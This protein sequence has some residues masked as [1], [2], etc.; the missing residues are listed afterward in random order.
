MALFGSWIRLLWALLLI[1]GGTTIAWSRPSDQDVAATGRPALRVFTDKDG[2]PQN[3]VEALAKD[4]NGYL[5]VG[6]QDGPARYNGRAWT[7]FTMPGPNPKPWIRCILPAS[8]GSLWFG[9]VLGGVIRFRE[10][11]W[12]SFGIT[13]QVFTGQVSCLTERMDG[14]ILAGTDAGVFQWD[15]RG[16][17]PLTDPSGQPTGPVRAI[18]EVMEPGRPPALWIG[19]ERGLALAGDRSWTWFT[20]RDGLPASEVWSLHDSH[21]KDGR[22]LLWVGTARGL[23]QWDGH[24][25]MAFGPKEGV[26]DN[27]VN[28]IVE[29]ISPMGE[30]TLWLATDSGLVFHEDG[31]WQVLGMD[32]GFPNRTVRSLWIE[33]VPGGERTIWAGTFG[34]LVRLSRGG[35]TTFDRQTGLPDNVVFAILESRMNTGF[36][37]GTLGGGLARYFE[38]QWQRYGLDSIIPDRHILSLL[39]TRSEAGQ[40]VLW[41]GCRSGGVLRVEG[42]RATRYTE[43]DGLPDTWTY[44]ISEIQGSTGRKEIWAGT[45]KGPAR[46]EGG[47]WHIPP[48]A[49]EYTW[50]TVMAIHQGQVPGGGTGLWFATRGQGLFLLQGSR[51]THFSEKEG[52]PDTRVMSLETIL[53]ADKVPWL[54]VGSLHGLVRRRLDTAASRWESIPGLPAQTVYST[55]ADLKGRVFVFTHRGVCQ[56]TPRQTTAENSDPFSVRVFTTGDGLPSNGCTQKSTL[57]DHKGRIWTGTVAGA[58]MYDP[59]EERADRLLKPLYFEAIQAGGQAVEVNQ[60]FEVDWRKPK[61]RFAFAL[62]NYYREE[63]T[64]YQ[65]QMLGLEPEPTP[66]THEATREFPSLPPGSYTFSVWARDAFGNATGPISVAFKVIPAPWETWWARVIFLLLALAAIVGGVW[67]RVRVLRAANLLL[68]KKVEARTHQLAEAMGDLELAREDAIKANQAKSFFLAT[69]SHEIRTPLNGIIGMS[70]AL[71]DMPLSST[72]RD[73]SETIHSSSEGLLSILNEILDFSKVESGRLELEAIAFDPVAELEECLGLFAE[74]AQRKGLELV[75]VFEPGIP[76]AVRGD[77]ARFRQVAVNL[78]GNAVKFTL[79]GEIRLKLAAAPAVDANRVVLQLEVTDTGIGIAPDG[80]MRLFTPFTQAEES[81]SRRYGGTG[82]GLSICKRIVELMGGAIRVESEVGSGTCFTCVIPFPLEETPASSWE[83][84]PEGLRVL[85]HE[86]NASV[87]ACIAGMLQEWGTAF[88]ILDDSTD[89]QT[90]LE[91]KAGPRVHLALLGL[92]PA[93]VDPERL[94]LM[95]SGLKVPLVL[96]VGVSAISAAEKLRVQ[97]KANYLTKPLRRSRL[98][99]A[100]RQAMEPEPWVEPASAKRGHVLVVDDNS[101]NRKVAELHLNSLGFTCSAVGSAEEAFQ[102]LAVESFDVVLMDCEMPEMD[103]FQ[104][105][106]H[107]RAQEG[108]GVH[109]VILALTAHSVDG[110]RT[111]CQAAGM[112]GFLSKPLRREPLNATLSRWI[113]TQGNAPELAAVETNLELDSHTWEG[114][115]YLESISGPGAIAELFEDFRKDAPARLERMTL[116]L[117]NQDFDGLR[118]LAH[119]LKSNSGTLGIT[120]L[121]QCA[122]DLETGAESGLAP[123]LARLVEVCR[124]LV[125]LALRVLQDRIP[126]G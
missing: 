10:G 23:G 44:A 7:S 17:R 55:L 102:R 124:R 116:C 74:T 26:P 123:E 35:W 15:Q 106:Q 34:G 118:R 27:V 78:L 92:A 57:L 62:L 1:V 122:A 85:I 56:L 42:G 109:Q 91:N 22:T 29:S 12:E 76:L 68:E 90:F 75:G 21:E 104:A 32:A 48:G 28:Q 43:K 30:H 125:P 8:D 70:G 115:L 16:W 50:G 53:D 31:K 4:R 63:D 66:W 41:I 79:E 110:A 95:A 59:K 112:D 38:G 49:E 84:L 103:G 94:V 86:P 99:Q 88:V 64:T 77:A 82:L 20:K 120:E 39:E 105:T 52:L 126:A 114:L 100:L 19:S 71:L 47:R 40:P 101:T 69:M 11:I 83:P 72:Q 113:G 107:I 67:A 24:R 25:W 58:A 14:T 54:W 81:T 119:D 9:Q 13:D 97:G 117:D 121:T 111:R 93:D 108:P 61:A 87:R 98:R 51:W 37:V 46:L 45:R 80:L 18:H 5:W 73:F 33:A 89:L 60:T 36:W 6:T 96:L 65:S 3:T 2:L